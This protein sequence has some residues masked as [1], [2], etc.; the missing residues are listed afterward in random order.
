MQIARANRLSYIPLLPLLAF[1]ANS[2]RVE[3]TDKALKVLKI[4]AAIHGLGQKETLEALIMRGASA[5][6]LVL[7][8]GKT[9]VGLKPMVEALPTVE[10]LPQMDIVTEKPT[11]L[12]LEEGAAINSSD[13][14]GPDV[15]QKR[16][17]LSDNPDAL[18]QIRDMWNT[19]EHNQAEIAR[20]IGRH[21]A[22]V[23]DNIKQLKAKG[24]LVD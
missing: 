16:K 2:P 24:E 1:M 10:L 21:R 6:T 19:G 9:L 12:Q 17:R 5:Q 13:S 7:V 15:S 22:T 4:E 14:T 8:E 20:R 18:Q 11:I 3:I 23:H